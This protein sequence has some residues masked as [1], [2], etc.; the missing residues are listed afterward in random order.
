MT[1]VYDSERLAAGYAF[2]RPPVHRHLLASASLPAR[3]AVRALDIGCGAG[4]STA[5]L[6]P[7]AEHVV[8]LEPIPAMLAH[9]HTVAPT[10][11]FALGAAERLPFAAASF[12]LVA[13]AG[14]LDY[15]DLP[16]ALAEVARV[17]TPDGL[18]LVYD[19]AKGRHSP[20]NDALAAWYQS[21]E[22]HFPS[23]PGRRPRLPLTGT[24]LHLLNHTD[25]E[26]P[27]PMTLDDYL[28]YVLS[29]VSVHSAIAR[30]AGTLDDIRAWCRS[31]LT[32]VFGDEELVVLFPGYVTTL[33]PS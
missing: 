27:L 8:G 20:T 33:V 29:E 1:S 15:T 7:L 6:I 31:T 22:H 9:R 3:P 30:G 32:E 10:A 4:V 13:A 5:A 19:F 11:R 14:S 26:I 18:F 28:R 17:L 16:A 25:V 12:D 2:D 21:F 24:G 23:S